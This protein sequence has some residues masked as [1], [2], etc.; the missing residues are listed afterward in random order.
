M[1]LLKS[2]LRKH[3]GFSDIP[4]KDVNGNPTIG[5]GHNLSMPITKDAAEKIL[6]NDIMIAMADFRRLSPAFRK[7]LNPNR[8]RVVAEM[9]FAMG[10]PAF[11]SFKRFISYTTLG[12]FDEAAQEILDSE[13][14]RT[15]G[16]EPGQ[17]AYELAELYREG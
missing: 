10:L 16:D 11:R 9:L 13:W 1:E 2:R 8:S 6:D 14:A 3:E 5:Y 7:Q 4:Y 15:V 17:R 12:M